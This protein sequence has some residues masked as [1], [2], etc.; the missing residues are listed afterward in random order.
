MSGPVGHCNRWT[1]SAGMIMS[2]AEKSQ[3]IIIQLTP[4][5]TVSLVSPMN[6]G[7]SFRD[8][9]ESVIWFG[10]IVTYASY[11]KT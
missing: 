11:K 10:N 1:W 4:A 7:A 9:R 5:V 3:E 6:D 8:Q 2:R